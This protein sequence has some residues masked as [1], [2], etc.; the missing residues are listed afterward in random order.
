MSEKIKPG[1]D[2]AKGENTALK[3][4]DKGNTNQNI[5]QNPEQKKPAI[6]LTGIPAPR[7]ARER[8]EAGAKLP[9]IQ[10]LIGTVWLSG[11][12]HIHFG[13]NGAGKSIMAVQW[14]ICLCEGKRLFGHLDNDCGP[15]TGIYYDFELTDRQ[16][17]QR[18]TD[19]TTGTEYPWPENLS[20]DTISWDQ[21]DEMNPG[22]DILTLVLAKIEHDVKE[23]E[24]KFIVIDNI[25]YLSMKSTSDA[26]VA[27]KIMRGLD[28]LKKN[29]GI[30]ILVLAHTPKIDYSVPITIN[31]LAGSK[32]LSNFIDSA[33]TLGKSTLAV[34]ARYLKQCKQRA[35]VQLYSTDHVLVLKLSKN[36][37]FTGFEMD[38]TGSEYDHLARKGKPKEDPNL[39]RKLEAVELK[40]QLIPIR[41]IAKKLGVGKST[42]AEWLKEMRVPETDVPF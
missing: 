15:L 2:Q 16:V 41:E 11:E 40:K 20:Y 27:L 12:L 26:E 18:Y 21:L 5:K 35:D 19:L 23:K 38:G 37:N 29:L 13:D 24:A 30:S 7:S 34:D 8:M 1:G 36:F 6:N 17:Y 10:C 14:A 42:V 22:I 9:P 31:N 28:A 39:A 32:M 33:S 25:S 3:E 4:R